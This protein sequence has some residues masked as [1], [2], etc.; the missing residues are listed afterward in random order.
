MLAD[1]GSRRVGVVD[2][3]HQLGNAVMPPMIT[4]L[5][6]PESPKPGSLEDAALN[7]VCGDV[8][9][10][11]PIVGSPYPWAKARLQEGGTQR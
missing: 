3:R 8:L 2:H 1:C 5:R 7:A 4:A 11:I 6:P 9:R 10:A